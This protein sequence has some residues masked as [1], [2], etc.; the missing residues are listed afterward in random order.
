MKTLS[1]SKVVISLLFLAFL[2]LRFPETAVNATE[3]TVEN[4]IEKVLECDYL[5][6]DA[7]Q[8]IAAL[9]SDADEVIIHIPQDDSVGRAALDSSS[10]E[11]AY[12]M[13]SRIIS[14][15]EIDG[16]NYEDRE[17]TLVALSVQNGSVSASGQQYGVAASNVVSITWTYSNPTLSDLKVKF[18]SMTAK[19]TYLPTQSAE[20]VKMEYSI[21]LEAGMEN[22][23]FK[24]FSESYPSAGVSYSRTLN[25]SEY[26]LGGDK[27]IAMIKIY[28]NNGSSS[29]YMGS[30]NHP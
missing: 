26:Y 13:I 3:I 18:N 29:E 25:S 10:N 15:Q 14:M 2:L 24:S 8:T 27:I 12:V 6:E 7:K 1:F 9:C 22:T 30:I 5:T 11:Q 4:S 23:Y 20:V 28:Y 19:Y 21:R 16:V 17:E